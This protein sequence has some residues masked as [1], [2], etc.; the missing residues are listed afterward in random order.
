MH[1]MNNTAEI[2]LKKIYTKSYSANI[3]IVPYLH[4]C[5]IIHVLC[6]FS[7]IDFMANQKQK[8]QTLREKK[9]DLFIV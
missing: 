1:T 3:C 8:K 9:A 5:C 4:F 2:L 7:V 6:I